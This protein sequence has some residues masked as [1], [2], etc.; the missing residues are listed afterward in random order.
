MTAFTVWKFEDPAG[1]EQASHLLKQAESEGLVKVLDHAVVSWPQGDPK[2]TTKHSH[3]ATVRGG[4]WG[5]LWGMV[6]GALFFVPVIGGVAG[7]A[8]GAISKATEGTGITKEQLER[9]RT[10]VTE[11]SS[12]L[13]MVTDEGDLD[14]LGDRF[15][16]M[17]KKLIETNLTDA[18]RT[19]LLQT[20]GGR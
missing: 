6:A 20:F 8:I 16:T 15:K 9:I 12:A 4:G 19:V 14:R 18:E 17:P 13:F 10:E 3:D 5:A 11:G 7:A 2:P 1:A